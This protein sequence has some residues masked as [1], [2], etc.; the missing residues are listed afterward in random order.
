MLELRRERVP[1]DENIPVGIMV[2]VP[3]AALMV[4]LFAEKVDFI[5]IGTNDLTQYTMSADRT[6]ERVASLYSCYHPSVL[7]LIKMTVDACKKHRKPV[8]I[9]GEVAGD[10]LALPLFFGMGVDQLSM[11]PAKIFDMCRLVRKV[12][13]GLVKHLVG[14]VMASTS[15]GSVTR[16]LESFRAALEK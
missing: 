10:L 15:V 2:E 3:S 14:S 7:H 12:D 6:N 5:S 1:F 11:N 16:R 9:C 8:S 4:D 13:S